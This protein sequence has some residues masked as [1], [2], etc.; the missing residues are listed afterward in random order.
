[1]R[2]AERFLSQGKIRAAIGEY[3]RVVENDPKDF[4]TL[5]I[6]GDLYAK[7]HDKQEAVGCFT[8]VADYYNL[9][10][11][12][13]K[14]IAVYNKISRIEPSSIEISAK[15]AEL[16]QS[17]GSVAEARVH[18]T[19][20]AEHYQ[21]KGQKIEALAIWRQIAELDRNNTEIYLKI[22][23]TYWQEEQFDEAA[24]AFT[25]AGLRFVNQGKYESALT[26]FARSLD[27]KKN[28]LR[29][30][31]GMVKAQIGLGYA[32]EAANTLEEVL[33]S[34]PHNR[35]ILNLLA[36]CYLEMNALTEAEQAIIK[37]VEQEPTSYPKFIDLVKLYLKN[38]NLDAATR[39]LSMSSEHLLVGG[40]AEDF[41]QW[42]TE[43]LARNPEQ[44][45][46]LRLLVRYNGW[47]RDEAALRQSLERLAETARL[48]NSVEHEHYALSQLVTL[49]PQETE[50][51]Q[52]LQ[53]INHAHGFST[54]LPVSESSVIAVT[55]TPQF[56]N[57]EIS[58]T[59]ETNGQNG[60]SNEFDFA[61]VQTPYDFE[62]NGAGA[63][64][65]TNGTNGFEF[66]EQSVEATIVEDDFQ[67]DEY[68]VFEE[69]V[70]QPD[71][72]L[73]LADELILRKELDSIEFYIEQ[74]Y[75]DLAVKSLDELETQ[76]GRRAE[77]IGFRRQLDN[78]LPPMP[79]AES[80][81]IDYAPAPSAENYAVDIQPA[82]IAESEP[83]K[84]E[85]FQEELIA[86]KTE[87]PKGFEILDELNAQFDTEESKTANA[88]EDYEMHY[89]LA[90]AY[91]E[92]G[93][94]EKAIREFQDAINL[95]GMNDG[96]RR[97][98]QCSHLLGHCFMEKQMPNLAITWFNRSLEVAD[99]D[100]DEKHA[101]YYEIGD[102]FESNSESQKAVNY[103]EKIYAEN[104]DFRDVS[105]RLE[106][107][108]QNNSAS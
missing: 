1:M 58:E 31:K 32:D 74:G 65:S 102:A 108:R 8:Q 30:L 2:N 13:H 27:I 47:Q 38:G 6:L 95:V 76:F 40:Q 64:D 97:F 45:D 49:A 34:Q 21:R 12:S 82:P 79:V 68:E 17:K 99:L 88:E 3:Q 81:T 14:A 86:E 25:E 18:Y 61:D 24:Q 91:K 37:L 42:T 92:M 69:A 87:S 20:L 100:D 96:T 28:D 70:E 5:N 101:L 11:F 104:V 67:A 33:K 107:L 80:Q 59:Q 44:L 54:E 98:F 93:L 71:S 50:Y 105:R 52:R 22:A 39:I 19:T 51:S 60:H 26:A 4:S 106:D 36:D 77:I 78:S 83:E 103:F 23:E 41:L 94:M 84:A 15:L 90:T 56:Q 35:D 72:E 48:N 10:G 53:E 9:Q 57:Y 46:A 85:I 66:Y 75:K 55:A 16:Y 63:A 7:N 29:A 43:I 62:S 89:H 73:K